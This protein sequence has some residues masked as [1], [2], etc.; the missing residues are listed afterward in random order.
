MHVGEAA[1]DAVKR[2]VFEETGIKYEVERLAFIHENFFKGTGT[3]EGAKCHEVA[4]P[5]F[6]ADELL[7]I[8]D[9]VKHI[10]T[11]E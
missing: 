5:S 9:V 1:E 2:E 7:N 10:V 3:L 11:H 4:Y 8:G 6:F